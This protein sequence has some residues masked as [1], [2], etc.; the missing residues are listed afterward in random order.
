MQFKLAFVSAALASLAVATP[1]PRGGEPA[2]S[3]TTGPV[4]CCNSV[5]SASS[6]AVG[7]LL[8]LLGIV[9]QDLN[10]NVGLTCS[11]ISVVGAGSTC[12]AQA[13]CCQDNSHGGLISIGCI[14]VQL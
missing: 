13:V 7:L 14:P 5:Q 6:G 12:S 10:V 8:G 3:C 9:L 1:T 2:S 4:Q 11:P